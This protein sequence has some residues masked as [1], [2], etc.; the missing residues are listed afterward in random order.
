MHWRR[1]RALTYA[2]L[3]I[4]LATNFCAVFFARELSELEWFG[5]PLSWYMAAQGMVLIDVL[6]V[7][8]YAW[9]MGR[10]DR[11]CKQECE[12]RP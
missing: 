12:D 1:T 3:A 4:W 8:I 7:G 10:L 6:I 9:R 2:L 11:Q 5:W